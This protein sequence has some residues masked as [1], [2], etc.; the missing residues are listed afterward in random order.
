M[1]SSLNYPSEGSTEPAVSRGLSFVVEGSITNSQ[2]TG[3][4]RRGI[5]LGVVD[6]DIHA[7]DM[8]RILHASMPTSPLRNF[9]KY[10][11]ENT[12]FSNFTTLLTIYALTGDDV[13]LIATDW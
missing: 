11:A 4:G 5:N 10:I 3:R 9:C 2:N 1:D 7:K 6:P 13:R 12:H 8:Q